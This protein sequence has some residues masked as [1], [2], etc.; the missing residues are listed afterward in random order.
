MVSM[1]IL[2]GLATIWLLVVVAKIAK[3]DYH[4]YQELYSEDL[5]NQDK[6]V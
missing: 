1:D 2:F 3:A 6:S 4:F 5:T